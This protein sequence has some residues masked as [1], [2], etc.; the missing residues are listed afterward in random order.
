MIWGDIVNNDEYFMELNE[1]GTPIKCSACNYANAKNRVIVRMRHPF[2]TGAWNYHKEDLQ[3][4][5]DV[6]T[7]I[8]NKKRRNFLVNTRHHLEHYLWKILNQKYLP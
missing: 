7:I 6:A 3:N 4:K 5:A 1:D 2:T 8:E